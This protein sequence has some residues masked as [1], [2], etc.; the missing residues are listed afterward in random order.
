MHTESHEPLRSLMK[1][2]NILRC[3]ERHLFLQQNNFIAKAPLAAATTELTGYLLRV[4]IRLGRNGRCNYPGEQGKMGN[5]P[6]T[7][8]LLV[9]ILIKEKN[10][11]LCL[12][13]VECFGIRGTNSLCRRAN[14]RTR[15]L[16]VP[17]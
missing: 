10:L 14:H 1:G 13:C 3:C 15:T 9:K 2:H 16:S 4:L 12:Y 7:V 8:V 17:A 6:A 5:I 11:N